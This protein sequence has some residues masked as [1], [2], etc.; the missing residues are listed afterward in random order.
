[1]LAKIISGNLKVDTGKQKISISRRNHLK[2]RLISLT[3][4][5]LNLILVKD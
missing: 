3:K 5:S 1:M 4:L 2:S